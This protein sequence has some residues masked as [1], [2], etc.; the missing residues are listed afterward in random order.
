MKRLFNGN[1][2][3][4]RQL[5]S[6]VPKIASNRAHPISVK[7]PVSSIKQLFLLQKRLAKWSQHFVKNGFKRLSF[8][9]KSYNFCTFWTTRFGLNFASMLS[10]YVSNDVWREFRLPV[11]EFTT[12]WFL[13]A[14]LLQNCFS[15]WAF[16][17]TIT[18]LTLDI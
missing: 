8:L 18:A 14:K 11:S 1:I 10:K 9:S 5:S 6:S 12:V 3:I 7:Q 4:F 13:M 2:L 15:D 16:Y 17:V